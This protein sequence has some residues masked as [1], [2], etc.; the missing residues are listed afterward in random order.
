MVS[1]PKVNEVKETHSYC[2]AKPGQNITYIGEIA[3]MRIF[4]SNTASSILG[5]SPQQFLAANASAL[6]AFAEV[7]L[8]CASVFGARRE[9]LH[10][11]YDEKGST[12]AFNQSQALFFNYR[13]FE[14]LHLPGV[15]QGHSSDAVIYWSVV[16]AHE[17]A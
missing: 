3:S 7:L 17:L 5:T 2:D 14:N 6:N 8:N 11:F 15:Q 10:I 12:I 16:M 9:S 13:Y 1:D 4:L